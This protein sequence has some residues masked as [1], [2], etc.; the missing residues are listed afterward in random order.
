MTP[1]IRALLA[2]S[3]VSVPVPLSAQR[4][5]ARW[6]DSSAA[7][8]LTAARGGRLPLQSSLRQVGVTLPSATLNMLADSL[9]QRALHPRGATPDEALKASD[10]VVRELRTSGRSQGE[11]VPY[12][13]ALS[14][15]IRIARESSDPRLRQGIVGGLLGVGSIEVAT[16]FLIDEALKPDQMTAGVA[17]NSLAMG[18]ENEWF[19]ARKASPS[20]VAI[21]R[22]ALRRI[23]D[24][25]RHP[26]KATGVELAPDAAQA[27]SRVACLEGWWEPA[28]A[29][30]NITRFKRGP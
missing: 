16:G 23:W 5:T 9:V 14:R 6:G 3:L 13:G 11:G 26:G 30:A 29:C 20:E 25:S 22:R 17:V 2:L 27:L 15:L 19:D 12:D 18:L 1:S 10:K 24:A 8:L 4:D 7:A 28:S 21:L